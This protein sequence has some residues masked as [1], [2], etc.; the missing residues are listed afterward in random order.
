MRLES[1][2]ALVTG[3]VSGLGLATAILFKAEGATVVVADVNEELG[4]QVSDEHGLEFMRLDVSDETSCKEV[5]SEII[6]KYG[7]IHILV[8]S[9]GIIRSSLTLSRKGVLDTEQFRTIMKIN[10]FGTVYCSAHAAFQMS[11]N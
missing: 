3:G 7:T 2:V 10:L 9:A 8:N 5:I 6:S 4:K 11:K 1:K